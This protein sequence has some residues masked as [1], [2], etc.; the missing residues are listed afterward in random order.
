MK[1][2]EK[3]GGSE[4]LEVD[5]IVALDEQVQGGSNRLLLFRIISGLS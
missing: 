1:E 4:S 2:R 3:R 5:G